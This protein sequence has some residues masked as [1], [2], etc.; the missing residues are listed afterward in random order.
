MK[1]RVEGIESYIVTLR[2]EGADGIV[3]LELIRHLS[4]ITIERFYRS[5]PI[6]GMVVSSGE[7]I[8][9][10]APIETRSEKS[11]NS[12]R[13]G[14]VAYSISKKMLLIALSDIKLSEPINPM[15]KVIS[16]MEFIRGLR[17]GMSV[18]LVR[19]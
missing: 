8:Y 18:E 16:G 15:G 5:L 4:P 7:L 13:R 19:S 10:S 11:R 2:W 1:E 9:I 3:Q 6:R 12:M 14:H 17:T